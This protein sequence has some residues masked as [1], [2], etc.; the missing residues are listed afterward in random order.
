[1][2]DHWKVNGAD[3]LVAAT[4][5]RFE[6][7]RASLKFLIPRSHSIVTILPVWEKAVRISGFPDDGLIRYPYVWDN[8]E[9]IGRARTPSWLARGPKRDSHLHRSG[10]EYSYPGRRCGRSPMKSLILYIRRSVGFRIHGP[11]VHNIVN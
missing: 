5:K 1:M 6:L 3:Y 4:R 9:R 2:K 7:G 10:I 11:H 8:L